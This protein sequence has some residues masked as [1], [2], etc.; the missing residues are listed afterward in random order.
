VPQTCTVHLH[1]ER[2]AIDAALLAGVASN[3]RTATQFNLSEAAVRRHRTAHLSAPLVK[4]Q[5]AAQAQA[6]AKRGE[7]L[8]DQVKALQQRAV[9]LLERAEAKGDHRTALLAI[10]ELAR[11]TDMLT[12]AFP[13]E[14]LEKARTLAWI[15]SMN[16]EEVNQYLEASVYG[17]D[18]PPGLG[19]P[20]LRPPGLW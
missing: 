10:R 17:Q 5:E 19:D 13:P 18:V 4:A 11:L 14:V 9:R 2:A 8:L 1:P 6:E 7:S 16:E 15:D 12:R 3:R 20:R